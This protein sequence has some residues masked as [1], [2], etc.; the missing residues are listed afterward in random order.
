MYE[1]NQIQGLVEVD[2]FVFPHMNVLVPSEIHHVLVFYYHV[3]MNQPKILVGVDA[4]RFELEKFNIKST[5]KKII[6]NH[7]R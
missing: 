3:T 5:A 7:T 1:K 4:Q 6:N 2:P